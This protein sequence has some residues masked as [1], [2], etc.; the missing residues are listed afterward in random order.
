MKFMKRVLTVILV[1]MMTLSL[2]S[3]VSAAEQSEAEYNLIFSVA[4]KSAYVAT[5]DM[6]WFCDEVEARTDGRVHIEFYC[7]EQLYAAEESPNAMMTGAIDIMCDGTA[8]IWPDFCPV[9]AYT[10]TWFLM[11]DRET[12][13]SKLP[14][15]K[16]I[17]F[18]L[19][20]EIGVKPL[21]FMDRGTGGFITKVDVQKPEDLKGLQ[22]RGPNSTDWRAMEVLG[23]TPVQ[24]STSEQY[25]ALAKGTLDGGRATYQNFAKNNLGE[26]CKYM[27]CNV[28][29]TMFAMIMNQGVWDS[30]PEDV[31]QVIQEVADEFEEKS[32]ND[33]AEEEAGY[34]D[35]IKEW[36]V[37][38]T[39]PTE[40]Q[41]AA[42]REALAPYY[43]DIEKSCEDAGYGEQAAALMEVF[44]Q[45]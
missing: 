27:F 42:F 31:Q 15:I 45:E 12:T 5:S 3:A 6:Q 17:L 32:F 40:E 2:V 21:A 26:F 38:V 28:S 10:E 22:M 1:F 18:P 44:T 20:E 24:M 9:F 43:A 30:L 34:I 41:I 39:I 8:N 4:S 14:Q 25:D 29:Y 19:W 35:K 16:E 11:T 13:H 23:V 37:Q 7:D 36:D 33:V